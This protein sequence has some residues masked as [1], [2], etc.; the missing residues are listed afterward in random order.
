MDDVLGLR[1]FV[2]AKEFETSVAFYEAL[3]FAVTHKDSGVALLKLGQFT[4]I[5]QNYYVEAFA[6]NCMVQLLV[7]DARAWWAAREPA[8]VAA[9]F[10]VK[11]PIPPTL[12]HWGLV[13][14]FIFDPSGVLWHVAEAPG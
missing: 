1:P 13:V 5:L 2:P 9:R 4:F 10:A 11:A 12:Q 14:G 3:G 7:R 8:T 6:E